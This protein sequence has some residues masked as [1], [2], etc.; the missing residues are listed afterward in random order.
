M[1]HIE[2]L[3][4]DKSA[5]IL[6]GLQYACQKTLGHEMEALS[7][8]MGSQTQHLLKSIREQDEQ[9]Q[10]NKRSIGQALN[11]EEGSG[12]TSQPKKKKRNTTTSESK[13]SGAVK[14]KHRSS[15]RGRNVGM[16]KGEGGWMG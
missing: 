13:S 16:G 6:I 8:R 4:Q 9:Q 15:R 14:G 7:P 2:Y 11:D 12:V 10:P 3:S 1:I 5:S